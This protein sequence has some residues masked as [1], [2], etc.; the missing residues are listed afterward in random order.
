MIFCFL[1]PPLPSFVKKQIHIG[2]SFDAKGKNTF[3]FFLKRKLF[4]FDSILQLE[5]LHG[6]SA[7][8]AR[9]LRRLER[10]SGWNFCIQ[11]FTPS[12]L[13]LSSFLPPPP[14]LLK[15]HPFKSLGGGAK[16]ML[17]LS[18]R[19]ASYDTWK[20]VV[21]EGVTPGS[22]QGKIRK[23]SRGVEDEIWVQRRRGSF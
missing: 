14:P 7:Q 4:P 10:R 17:V 9:P 13:L 21:D 23:E 22:G 11:F 5:A 18:Q 20:K 19:K 1:P 8:S 3:T 2:L 12:V 6:Q 15:K 16:E